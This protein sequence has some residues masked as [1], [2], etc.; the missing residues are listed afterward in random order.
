[1]LKSGSNKVKCGHMWLSRVNRCHKDTGY[2]MRTGY[3]MGND[4][5]SL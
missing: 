1:M 5:R 3:V 4:G 2:D